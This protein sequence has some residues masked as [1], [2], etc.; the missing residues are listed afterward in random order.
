V[1]EYRYGFNGKEEVDEMIGESN[2]YDFGARMYDAR[3]GRWWS[4][5]GEFAKYPE[6]G[7]YGF[8]NNSPLI[9]IDPDGNII[10]IYLADGNYYDYSPGVE[11]A[12]KSYTIMKVHQAITYNMHTSKGTEVW[13]SLAASEQIVEIRASQE[14]DNR[15]DSRGIG[16]E[17]PGGGISGGI[18]YWDFD[19]AFTVLT[20]TGEDDKYGGFLKG[21]IAP[22]TILLHEAGHAQAALK[23]YTSSSQ[24]DYE[25]W[26]ANCDELLGED[27]QYDTKEEKRN[28]KDVEQ[29]YL[30]EIN[31]WEKS[32]KGISA[33]LQPLRFNHKG[34]KDRNVVKV[35]EVPKN[36]SDYNDWRK[37]QTDS[38]N[39]VDDGTK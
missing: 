29:V 8:V 38:G 5:D 20:E 1:E 3:L 23:A 12:N 32:N 19:N 15:F 28:I 16:N 27:D 33:V 39:E 25:K 21:F 6:V 14:A 13:N 34:T 17:M 35:N 24:G 26:K 30:R 31:A 2:G 7:C 10:R 4:V 11:P 37:T 18:I 36:N 22:S 9:L